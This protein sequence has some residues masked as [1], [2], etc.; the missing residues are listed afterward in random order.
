MNR[1]RLFVI[2][3]PSGTGK[4]TLIRAVLDTD[5]KGF[6]HLVHSVSHTTR[7]ARRG[8]VDGVDYHFIGRHEFEAMIADR[9]FLEWAEVFGDYKGT[10][11]AE[12]EPR[13]S[14]GID[15]ILDID[16]QGA[17]QLFDS[18]PDATS[19]FILPPS[20]EEM[21]RRLR[22]RGLDGA[23]QIRRRL[24]LSRW[25]IERYTAYDYAIINDDVARASEA[26]AA[27][28]LDKRHRRERMDAQVQIILGG[29]PAAGKGSPDN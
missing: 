16:V 8:E 11:M 9:Q 19:I 25:E 27:I 5:V 22:T 13:L 29:F 4:N 1:G 10:S 15:V 7:P 23:D 12:V 21:E 3:A 17:L 24:S 20:R 14:A 28:I 6:G 18:R 26:L 2:S